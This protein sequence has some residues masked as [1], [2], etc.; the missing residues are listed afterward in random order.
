MLL[1]AF[2][3]CIPA[4]QAQTAASVAVDPVGALPNAPSAQI[5]PRARG[6]S[7]TAG[8]YTK[9]VG[10]DR[11]A[12]PLT[13]ADKVAF[14]FHDAFSPT[15]LLVWV[16]AAGY[17]QT[18]NDSPNYGQNNLGFAKR[19]GAAGLRDSSEGIFTD[20]LFAP[21]YHQDPRY[22]KLGP[23]HGAARRVVYAITRPL[24]GRTDAGRG[25]P[26]LALLSGDF[27]GAWLTEAYY[28]QSDRGFDQVMKTYGGSLGSTALGNLAQEFLDDAIQFGHHLHRD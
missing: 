16:L 6:A 1:A 18:L 3:Y 15:S 2:V 8:I 20:S 7:P 4:A 5:D 22:Y 24:I 13:V 11:S 19:V 28:P 12:Q 9:Y 27:F 25:M 26:N 23:R 10:A 21:I 14:G 17:E